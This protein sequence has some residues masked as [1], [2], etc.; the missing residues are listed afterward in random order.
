MIADKKVK[1]L[2]NFYDILLY[3]IFHQIISM[4][5]KAGGNN[6]WTWLKRTAEH[7]PPILML[8]YNTVSWD[9]GRTLSP[10]RD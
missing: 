4:W 5:L 6:K 10:V 9:K 2:F 1:D 7:S 3:K 8:R